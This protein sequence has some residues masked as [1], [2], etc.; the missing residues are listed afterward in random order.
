MAGYDGAGAVFALGVR[1]TKLDTTGAPLTGTANS[2][3]T[4]ALVSIS[5]GQTYSSPD[6]IELKNG[7]GATCVFYQPSAVLLGGTISDFKFCT[8]DPNV[9]AFC[10]GG[11]VITSGGT[12]E[13]QTVTI[14]GAPTGGTFTLTFNGQTTGAIAYNAISSVVQTALVALSNIRT[15]DVTVT[16]GPGPATPYVVAFAGQFASQADASIPA[17]TATGSFTGGTSPAVAV[18]TSTAGVAGTTAIGYRAPAVNVNATP[19]GVA[20]EAWQQGIQNNAIAASL[21]YLHWVMPRAKL[22]PAD[23]YALSGTDFTVPSFSGTI[24]P[25]SNFGS[26][27]AGDIS[28][29]TDRIFQYCREASLPNLDLG[30]GAVTVTA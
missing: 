27:G 22:V 19:N 17:M 8:P 7:S 11:D 13:Q 30:F 5:V 14:T 9:L 24:E 3:S 16:G 23:N 28:F 6:S 26:G 18:T 12:N 10:A 21:P 25:N 1:L 15:G 20:I 4:S 29:A 2:Y